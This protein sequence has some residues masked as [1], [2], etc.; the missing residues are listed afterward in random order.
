MEL[1]EP[2]VFKLFGWVSYI[3]V[4]SAPYKELSM[5]LIFKHPDFLF[6]CC[7]RISPFSTRLDSSITI[8]SAHGNDKYE[9]TNITNKFKTFL[10]LYWDNDLNAFDFNQ[11]I[12]LFDLQFL[13]CKY[14]DDSTEEIY[15]LKAFINKLNGN[16]YMYTVAYNDSPKPWNIAPFGCIEF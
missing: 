5:R 12:N 14:K 2:I 10:K 6:K 11:F 15:T 13:D 9:F 4:K 8:I 16:V 3:S 7:G 1:I